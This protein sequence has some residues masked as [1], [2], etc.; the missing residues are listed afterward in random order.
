ME[1]VYPPGPAAVPADLTYATAAYRRHAWLAMGGLMLFVVL[2]FALS[3]WFTWT[4]YRLLSGVLNSADDV[5]WTIVGGMCSA[6][7][8]MFMLKALFLVKHR[9]QINEVE[10]TAEQQPQLFAFLHRLADEANA[11]RAHRVF[12]SPRVNAAVFYD[13]S[14]VN[15][16]FPTKKNLEIG[17]GLVNVLTLGEF[18]AVLAHE[19][20]HFAQRSMAVGRWVYVAQQV[21]AHI[22][23]KRDALDTFLKKLSRIDIRIAWV[24]WLLSLTIWSIRS[25]M[26]T[27]FR[28]VLL[29]QRALSREMEFQADLVAVSLTGSDALIHALHRLGAADEAW[30]RALNFASAEAHDGRA[31]EDIFAIQTRVTQHMR[32]ILGDPDYGHVPHVPHQRPESH[33]IFKAALAQAPRMWSTHPASFEREDNAKRTYIRVPIDERSAWTLFDDSQALKQRMSKHIVV[34]EKAQPTPLEASLKKLDEQYNR[35]FLNRE[36]RGAYLGRSTVRYAK[37]ACELY[38]VKINA[39]GLTAELAGLYPESL[40]RNLQQLRTLEEEKAALEALHKGIANAPGGIVR[41]RGQQVK[42]R[43]LPNVIGELKGEIDAVRRQVQDHDRRCRTAHLAAAA[44]LGQ[45]WDEYLCGLA[46]LLHYADHSE[47]NLRDVQGYLGNVFAVVTADG[48]VS[49]RELARLLKAAN[50][51]HDALSDLYKSAASVL[52]DRTLARRMEVESWQQALGEFKLP[53]ASK[54]NISNWLGAVD[55]CVNAAAG[56][57]S[58]LRLCSLEQLLVAEAQVARFVREGVTPR[59]APTASKAPARYPVLTPGEERPRQAKLDLWDRFQLADGLLATIARLAVAASIVGAILMVG[60]SVG[61]STISIY[62]GLAIAVRADIGDQ[63]A[64]VAPFA[65]ARLTLSH[66]DHCTIQARTADGRQIEAFTEDLRGSF[67]HYVYNV[68]GASPLV[69]WTAVYGGASPQPDRTLGAPRWTTTSASVIFAQPPASVSTRS[70]GTTRQVLSALADRSAFQ[71]LDAMGQQANPTA[72]ITVHAR[73]DSTNSKNIV[74][75]LGLASH[76]DGFSQL[77]H[78]RLEESPNDVV[79]L[80]FEQETA[81][82]DSARASVCSRHSALAAAAPVNADLQYLVDRC[83]RE[84]SKRNEAFIAHYQIAPESGWLAMA[85]GYTFA[86]RA[87]WSEAIGPLSVGKHKLPAMAERLA[88]DLARIKRAAAQNADSNLGDLQRDSIALRNLLALEQ[89]K[90][91]TGA[92]R[93]YSELAQGNLE[94]AVKLAQGDPTLGPRILRLAAASDGASR[95]MIA[96]A[97]LLP[98]EANIDTEA[99]WTMLGLTARE[100]VSTAAYVDV[101]SKASTGSAD[102]LNHFIDAIRRD[103]QL[104][105]RMLEGA[106]AAARGHAYAVGVIV[107]GKDAPPKWRDGAKRLLFA[108][109]RPHFS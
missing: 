13:L 14:I 16:L 50:E 32:A 22:I 87:Q 18:K 48:R 80:R 25:L 54:E 5:V 82:S 28:L 7:L 49:T 41:H 70:G 64:E 109:E 103:P 88:L 31:V 68:A 30:D 102:F 9:Y 47:A 66:A 17:L 34:S 8:A 62:N 106:D 3:G 27:L 84:P 38:G 104:A 21:A 101:L 39:Q 12:L 44:H 86:E 95:E 99:A 29:A 20:G 63:H 71:M 61:E 24:G 57:L 45:G 93:A 11:P 97:L 56:A 53:P 83:I 96:K 67:S 78:T 15:L 73:W 105:E 23:A 65:T 77:L 90:E 98:V 1:S 19:F 74:N 69:E 37:Q 40:A 72:L 4:A 51:L 10:I 35:A 58:A 46:N 81:Q 79:L 92:Y 26:E 108:A 52:L 42:R 89:G 59:E 85:V 2:Y 60:G 75:W 91:I 76:N 100:R 55:S 94:Q 43:D 33:R 6:F 107:L 36:Y